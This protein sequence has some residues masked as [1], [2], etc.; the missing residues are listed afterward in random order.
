[1][2]QYAVVAGGGMGIGEAIARRFHKDGWT[3]TIVDRVAAMADSVAN[4]LGERAYA[5]CADIT[6]PEQIAA[7][8]DVIKARAG[9][10]GVSAAVNAVGIYDERRPLLKT[11]L[12]SYQRIMNV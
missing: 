1:M 10:A 3:V 4:D 2:T 7:V 12:A 11:D 9:A 5:E 6:R 8:M